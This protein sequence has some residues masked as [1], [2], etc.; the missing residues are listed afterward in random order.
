MGLLI[1]PASAQSGGGMLLKGQSGHTHPPP[2]PLW[3]GI[4]G[5]KAQ[6]GWAAAGGRQEVWRVGLREWNGPGWHWL[7]WSK[8]PLR[9][10]DDCMCPDSVY[11]VLSPCF[12]SLPPMTI[13]CHFSL[14]LVHFLCPVK[15][16]P[17]VFPKPQRS[18]EGF[19]AGSLG[20]QIP[21][22]SLG[23]G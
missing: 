3:W 20:F 21:R 10:S 14:I 15:P 19:S 2:S 4:K 12:L 9:V 22:H 13:C 8:E 6:V 1:A 23:C 16:F 18:W 17:S 5:G 11:T 7:F